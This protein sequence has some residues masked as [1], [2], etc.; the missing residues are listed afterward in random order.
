MIE[1]KLVQR[2]Y[3]D[4]IIGR[5]IYYRLQAIRPALHLR[6]QLERDKE[7]HKPKGSGSNHEEKLGNSAQTYKKQKPSCDGL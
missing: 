5:M 7:H 6:M 1:R 3:F 2:I 4:G